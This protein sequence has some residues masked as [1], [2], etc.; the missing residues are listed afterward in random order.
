MGGCIDR[1]IRTDE[2]RYAT[3]TTKGVLALARDGHFVEIDSETISGRSKAN[4]LRKALVCI[5][6]IW[7]VTR[8]IVGKINGFP[9][10][11]IEVHTMIHVVCALS[12]YALWWKVSG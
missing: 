6:V 4:L 9:L 12:M 10:A 3:I 7:F 8:C 11:L 1:S 5:Q 2:Y